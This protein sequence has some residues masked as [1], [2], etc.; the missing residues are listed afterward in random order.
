MLLSMSTCATAVWNFCGADRSWCHEQGV[1]G[2]DGTKRYPGQVPSAPM[3]RTLMLTLPPILPISVNRLSFSEKFYGQYR[4]MECKF[5][6]LEFPVR[7]R[8]D[9]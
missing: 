9:V 4:R 8:L 3:R 1:T 5:T 2:S 7:V 6:T